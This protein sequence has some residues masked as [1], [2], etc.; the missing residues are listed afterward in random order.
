MGAGKLGNTS[1][2][3]P[4]PSALG[5]RPNVSSARDRTRSKSGS[6][7]ASIISS[8]LR[9]LFPTTKLQAAPAHQTPRRCPPWN[10]CRVTR[11]STSSTTSTSHR[12]GDIDVQ[13]P[14][15]LLSHFISVVTQDAELSFVLNSGGSGSGEAK[16]SY[17]VSVVSFDT[18]QKNLAALNS[19]LQT[20]LG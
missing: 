2:Q 9:P 12:S 5:Y 18:Y 16:K 10:T 3:C 4:S 1:P 6:S 7:L 20:K 13:P 19:M 17:L 14:R 11:C 8:S 15:S